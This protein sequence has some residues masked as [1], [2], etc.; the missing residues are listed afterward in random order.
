MYNMYQMYYTDIIDYGYIISHHNTS[1]YTEAR[2][3]EIHSAS[4]AGSVG[5]DSALTITKV[6]ALTHT[7]LGS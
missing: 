3:Q 6:G 2:K 4:Q 1:A 7:S 5:G